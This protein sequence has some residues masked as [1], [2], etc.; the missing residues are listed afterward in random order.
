MVDVAVALRQ[1][2]P[3][4]RTTEIVKVTVELAPAASVTMSVNAYV[5]L[6]GAVPVNTPVL[7]FSVTQAGLFAPA[8][9]TRGEVPPAAWSTKLIDLFRWAVHDVVVICGG[10][11]TTNEYDLLAVPT[12]DD[13]SLTVTTIE[14]V[15]GSAPATF[16]VPLTRP[17]PALIESPAGRPVAAHV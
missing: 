16:G 15:C 10:G 13:E 11:L 17:V 5:P 12:G 9:H 8:D 7:P 4:L 14:N 3:P 6:P 2:V 1:Q